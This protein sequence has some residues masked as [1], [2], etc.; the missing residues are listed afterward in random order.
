MKILLISFNSS[1]RLTFI[2]T[3]LLN[4]GVV[5]LRKFSEN[6]V[7]RP[8]FPRIY[9]PAPTYRGWSSCRVRPPLW[10]GRRITSYRVEISRNLY[11][12]TG[13]ENPIIFFSLNFEWRRIKKHVYI[14]IIWYLLSLRSRKIRADGIRKV[15]LCDVTNEALTQW[16][17]CCGSLHAGNERV[18]SDSRLASSILTEVMPG[19]KTWAYAKVLRCS[20]TFATCES[21]FSS[22]NIHTFYLPVY[23]FIDHL[24]LEIGSTMWY[25]QWR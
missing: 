11:N 20:A 24:Y 8:P 12:E 6:C 16:Y 14:R 22:M 15:W 21:S 18:A 9:T 23:S 25:K 13:R 4:T 19:E 5:S 2:V 7:S 10:S 17:T 1:S 3:E